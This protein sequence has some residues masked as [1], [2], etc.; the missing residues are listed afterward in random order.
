MSPSAIVDSLPVVGNGVSKK[1]AEEK[2]VHG[3]EDKTPLQ[4]IS[5]GEVQLQGIL[6]RYTVSLLSNRT[7]MLRSASIYTLS[8]AG[9]DLPPRH[10]KI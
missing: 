3:G 7:N 4:A 2:H 8:C 5:H 6:N 9:A 1:D 10:P